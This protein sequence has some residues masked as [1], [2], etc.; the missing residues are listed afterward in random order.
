MKY[1]CI[2][3]FYYILTNIRPVFRSTLPCVQLL[4]IAK[5]DDIHAYGVKELLEPFVRSM[6][7]LAQVS[8]IN[9]FVV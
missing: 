6:K 3:V 4:A 2:G 1:I 8:F 7:L 5:A 9:L